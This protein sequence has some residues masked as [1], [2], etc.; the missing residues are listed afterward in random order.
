MNHIP[1]RNGCY[2]GVSIMTTVYLL[3]TENI[4]RSWIPFAEAHPENKYC[5]FCTENSPTVP[6]ASVKNLFAVMDS[7][8][9]VQCYTGPNALD[10]Q[11]VSSLGF[12]CANDVKKENKYII[13]SKDTGYDAIIRFWKDRGYDISKVESLGENSDKALRAGL[14]KIHETPEKTKP[15]TYTQRLELIESRIDT[16]LKGSGYSR[17]EKKDIA[18]IVCAIYDVEEKQRM[19]N[20]HRDIVNL[21]G[22]KPGT[23]MYQNVKTAIKTL[24]TEF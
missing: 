1:S 18:S 8:E 9:F 13:V 11:L 20:I 23:K 2:E 6:L 14:N 19:Y 4:G 12:F 24:F 15:S 17:T 10:F 21:Y 3:D 5:L 16:L 7:L 22:Q